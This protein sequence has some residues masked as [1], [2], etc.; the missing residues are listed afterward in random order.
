MASVKNWINSGVGTFDKVV[1]APGIVS[2]QAETDYLLGM[3]Q[4]R[5]LN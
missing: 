5:Y 1:N 2:V 3:L 4:K